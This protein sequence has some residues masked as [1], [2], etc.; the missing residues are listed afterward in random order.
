MPQTHI[1]VDQWIELFRA[2]GLDQGAMHRWHQEFEQRHPEAHQSFLEWLA[3][4]PE[5]IREIRHES[6][7]AS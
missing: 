3:L 7:R 1:N 2:I 4:P 6:E 5:R